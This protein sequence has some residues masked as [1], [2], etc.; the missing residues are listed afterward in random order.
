MRNEFAQFN[1]REPVSG[2]KVVV[3]DILIMNLY[4]TILCQFLFIKSLFIKSASRCI[5]HTAG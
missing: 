4:V 5:P 2:W 3:G 1:L